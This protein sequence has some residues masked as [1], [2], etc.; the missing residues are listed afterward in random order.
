MTNTVAFVLK[1]YPRLSETFI[2]QEIHAL[3]TRG[4]DIIIVSLRHPTDKSVHPIHE[5]IGARV[6][7]LPEYLHQ[8]PVRVVRAALRAALRKRLVQTLWLF[9]RDL[10]RDL[11]VNR[12]RRFGQALVLADELGHAVAL[13][14]AHFM[15]T[16]GSVARYASSLCGLEFSISAHAKD[17]WTIPEWEKREKL[18]ACRW[19]V[20]CTRYNAQHLASLSPVPDRVELVY[21]GLDF[22][23]FPADQ[24]AYS[25]RDGSSPERAVRILSVG[26]A[27]EKKGYD[28]LIT[29]LSR[30]SGDLHWEFHHVGGGPLLG[31][32]EQQARE[33]CLQGRFFWHGAT[34]QQ[35]V[36][37]RA[38]AADLFVLPCRIADDG[39]R[40]GLPNV[41]ME[42]QC[43]G[44]ACVSTDISAVPELI[45]HGVTGV[46]VA[47]RDPH[48]LS[49]ALADLI[50]A[51]SER[52]RLGRAG[53]ERV[54]NNFS[55]EGGV[56]RLLEKFAEVGANAKT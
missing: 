43:V 9:L 21:H 55:F 49:T 53:R 22:A 23:R 26:R 35:G 1:G 8:E 18:A 41:L 24:F 45:E 48:A 2:A 36:I 39:D 20:T 10:K 29:A 31:Q 30:L 28:D 27:V 5:L 4:L 42:A 34:S 3:E 51:P 52:E 11:S 14:H 12:L 15:H 7:Y 17:I 38:L 33:Q 46:L 32:L 54:L 6:L 56:I 44:L 13:M 50:V 40:D 25:D 37:E 19:T 16:P 47:E